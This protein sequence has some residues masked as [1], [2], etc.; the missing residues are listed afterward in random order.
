MMFVSLAFGGV[1]FRELRHALLRVLAV[2]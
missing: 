1:Q 2:R